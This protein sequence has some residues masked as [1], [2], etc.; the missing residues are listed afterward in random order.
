M[1]VGDCY[2]FL[3]QL[4]KASPESRKVLQTGAFSIRRTNKSYSRSAIDLTLEQTVNRDAASPMRGIVGFHYSHDAIRRWCIT[5][6]QR[7]MSVTELRSMTGLE[8]D[9]QP[10]SQLK[11][12]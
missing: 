7:R 2:F 9:E 6:K 10:A 1:L 5:S 11:S 4:E 12:Q 3:N 8:I